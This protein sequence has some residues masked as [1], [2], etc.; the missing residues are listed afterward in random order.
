VRI[1]LGL[2]VLAWPALGQAVDPAPA[3]EPA[4]AEAPAA[5]VPF[6]DTQ[7]GFALDL[8]A[9]WT[10]ERQR[11]DGPGGSQGVLR[12]GTLGDKSAMQ[13]LLFRDVP[14][15]PFEGWL[16]GFGAAVRRIGGVDDLQVEPVAGGARPAGWIGV[17]ARVGGQPVHTWYYCV[18][19]DPSLVWVLSVALPVEAAQADSLVRPAMVGRMAESL[20]VL[21][22]RER[23]AELEAARTAGRKWLSEGG[24]QS[25]IGQLRVDQEPR[26]YVIE[27]QGRGVGYLERRFTRQQHSIDDPRVRGGEKDGLR[28]SERAWRFEPDGRALYWSNEAFSSVDGTTDLYE[29]TR[30]EVPPDDGRDQRAR[31]EREEVIRQDNRLLSS[32]RTSQDLV[33]PAPRPPLRLDDTYLGLAW[34]RVWPTMLGSEAGAMIGVT[35]YDAEAR[36]LALLT[37]RPLGPLAADG[38]KAEPGL[39]YELQQGFSAAP[40]RLVT[41]RRGHML[42]MT[43]GDLTYRLVTPEEIEQRFARPREAAFRKLEKAS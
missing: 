25:G 15:D 38:D 39:V 8:P 21:Y 33:L 42:E 1:G 13:V 32:V 31:I 23:A 30:G 36:T 28:V 43:V 12:G 22:S 6:V 24:L 29:L 20:Q 34:Q 7:E 5:M 18:A 17:R 41:D 3:G 2:S 16:R 4:A 14:A 37:G 35:I 40:V 11:F 27:E 9:H 26:Y 19:F 10:L